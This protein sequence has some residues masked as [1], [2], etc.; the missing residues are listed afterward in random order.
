MKLVLTKTLPSNLERVIV[1][2]TDITFATDIAEL[3]AVFHKFKGILTIFF[4][5]LYLKG[6]GKTLKQTVQ[7]GLKGCL[8]FAKC[9]G[10]V[11]FWCL[12]IIVLFMSTFLND[13]PYR[14]ICNTDYLCD[15]FYWPN[16]LG[17]MRA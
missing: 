4:Y 2:D 6:E 1:L 12:N 7:Q 13:V 8:W 5:C 10:F 9:F 17:Q 11:E 14:M 16:Y 3:W 15:L